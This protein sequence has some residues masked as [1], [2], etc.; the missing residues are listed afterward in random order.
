MLPLAHTPPILWLGR[1][2]GVSLGVWRV[3]LGWEE[4]RWVVYVWGL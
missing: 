4:G 3:R 2:E 1:Q